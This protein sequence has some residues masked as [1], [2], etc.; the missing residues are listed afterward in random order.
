M[1]TKGEREG[2]LWEFHRS[3]MSVAEAC[4]RLPAVPQRVEPETV[5]AHGGGG[6]RKFLR[7]HQE[8]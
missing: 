1:Y 2:M 6:R 5:A 3:G 8:S 7:P 4:R